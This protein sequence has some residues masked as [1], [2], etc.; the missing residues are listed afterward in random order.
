MAVTFG[1][2]SPLPQDGYGRHLM[3]RSH[4]SLLATFTP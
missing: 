2:L 1:H 4:I 3:S